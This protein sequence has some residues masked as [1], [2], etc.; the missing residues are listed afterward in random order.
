MKGTTMKEIEEI[1]MV[2]DTQVWRDREQDC[3]G[4]MD[5][6]KFDP[7]LIPKNWLVLPAL[8]FRYPCA[9]GPMHIADDLKN[10]EPKV[11]EAYPVLVLSTPGLYHLSD[12]L[13]FVKVVMLWLGMLEQETQ[14]YNR[15]FFYNITSVQ[16]GDM[17]KHYA[18]ISRLK[19]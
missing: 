3:K 9:N 12:P 8:I 13:F 6:Y 11:Y 10:L 4:Q 2:P 14:E 16:E 15:H 19:V 17:V 5:L 18:V 7:N 1:Q